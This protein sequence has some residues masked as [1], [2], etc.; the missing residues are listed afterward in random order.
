MLRVAGFNDALEFFARVLK[1][2]LF[3]SAN[4]THLSRAW[5]ILKW[6]CQPRQ[7]WVLIALSLLA[8]LRSTSVS[9]W[10]F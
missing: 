3:A 6:G 7:C 2:L 4:R 5:R 10:G 8:T 1:R 9:W